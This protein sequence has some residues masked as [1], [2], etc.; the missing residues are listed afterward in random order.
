MRRLSSMTDRISAIEV[1][2]ALTC[3][4]DLSTY[5]LLITHGS[6]TLTHCD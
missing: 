6:T 4:R 1:R 5:T 2:V 3:N